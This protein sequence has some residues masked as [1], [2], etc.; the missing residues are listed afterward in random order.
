MEY[1]K[2]DKHKKWEKARKRMRPL[3]FAK[4][5]SLSELDGEFEYP[6][7]PRTIESNVDPAPR[8]RGFWG[9]ELQ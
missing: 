5:S 4:A 6:P 8:C 9:P 1:L 7:T 2:S 3:K